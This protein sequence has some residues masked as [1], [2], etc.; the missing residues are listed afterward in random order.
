[1]FGFTEDTSFWNGRATDYNGI[2]E[3]DI[4]LYFS[5]NT[6]LKN[7]ELGENNNISRSNKREILLVLCPFFGA[8]L[9]ILVCCKIWAAIKLRSVFKFA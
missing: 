4:S 5:K 1:M 7:G 8:L 6:L 2:L 3:F 9:F